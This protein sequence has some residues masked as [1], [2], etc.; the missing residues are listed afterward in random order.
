V[1]PLFLSVEYTHTEMGEA[2]E[3][4][5][6]AGFFREGNELFTPAFVLRMLEYQHIAYYFDDDYKVR[7]MDTNCN[8]IEL[9]SNT[10][11]VITETGYEFKKEVVFPPVETDGYLAESDSSGYL[12]VAK[13]E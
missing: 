11:I 7:I 9:D 12:C 2:I 8:I 6:D 5:M 4:K 3:L 13:E 10:Y 1:A